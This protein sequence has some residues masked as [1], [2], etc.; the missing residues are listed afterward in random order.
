MNDQVITPESEHE[1]LKAYGELS[2]LCGLFLLLVLVAK[3]LEGWAEGLN[4]GFNLVFG[5]VFGLF[6]LVLLWRGRFTLKRKF[7]GSRQAWMGTYEDEFLNNVNL[8]AFKVGF[9]SIVS[10]CCLGVIGTF[11]QFPLSLQEWFSSFLGLCL[12]AY[13][14]TVKIGLRENDE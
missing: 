12:M 7:W 9:L 6:L 5:T 14:I 3:L 1:Y 2:L 4:A 11:N 8:K 10:L 13:G